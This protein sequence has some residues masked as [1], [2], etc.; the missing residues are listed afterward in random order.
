MMKALSFAAALIACGTIL[1]HAQGAEIKL[2]RTITLP[3][4]TGKFDHFA[5]DAAGNRLFAA[6]TG[7]QSV[8]IL[9]LAIDKVIGSLKGLGKPHGLAWIPESGRLFVADGGKAELDVFEGSPLKLAQTIPLTEDADDMVYDAA[10]RLLYVGHGGT[11]AANPARVAVIDAQSLKIVANLPVATHPEALELDPKGDRIFV[12]VAD[13]GEIAVIDGKTQKVVSTWMLKKE[14]GNTPLAY[15]AADD[16]LLVGC[17]APSELVVLNGRTGEEIAAAVTD[18]GADDLFYNASARTAYLVAGSGAVDS[19][20]VSP[21]GKLQTLDVT[22]TANGAK[23]GLLVSTQS[24][25]YVGIPGAA[26][27][28]RVYQIHAK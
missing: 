2:Q 23:T 22:R 10:T 17:R 7:N 9:D 20:A 15:D 11:N 25:L 6:A 5:I 18:A 26:A 4:V 21:E 28:I 3:G 14:K 8:E 24:A 13:A 27:T 12:N 1:C 19:F 16:L